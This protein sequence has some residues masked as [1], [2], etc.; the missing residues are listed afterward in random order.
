MRKRKTEDVFATKHVHGCNVVSS[1]R[2]TQQ[3][4]EWHCRWRTPCRRCPPQTWP[5]RIPPGSV[6]CPCSTTALLLWVVVVAILRETYTHVKHNRTVSRFDRH[7]DPPPPDW[8]PHVA[9][10]C[11]YYLLSVEGARSGERFVR[12]RKRSS[13]LESIDN[14]GFIKQHENSRHKL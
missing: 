13:Q 1:H 6:R 10:C 5:S 4:G 3:D 8:V 9:H 14:P 11:L 12:Q 7:R 2:E